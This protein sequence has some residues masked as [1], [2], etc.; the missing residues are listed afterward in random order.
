MEVETTITIAVSLLV[1]VN[2]TVNIFI[3]YTVWIR[4]KCRPSCPNAEVAGFLTRLL[5]PDGDEAR[6]RLARLLQDMGRSLER[7]G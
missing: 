1:V 2:V 6:R 3:G 4:P 7:P 5:G